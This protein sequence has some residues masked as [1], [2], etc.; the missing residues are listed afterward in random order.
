VLDGRAP[1]AVALIGSSR[2]GGGAHERT[3]ATAPHAHADKERLMDVAGRLDAGSCTAATRGRARRR[4]PGGRRRGDSPAAPTSASRMT[5]KRLGRR[6]PSGRQCP[7][8]APWLEDRRALPGTTT[9]PR[10][11]R[12]PRWRHGLRRRR[13]PCGVP[14]GHSGEAVETWPPCS[15]PLPANAEDCRRDHRR[16]TTSTQ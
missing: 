4:Q 3:L 11:R 6:P 2:H 15:L 12:G 10:S 5:G 7:R 1:A 9:S 13:R 14:Q 16:V 8:E